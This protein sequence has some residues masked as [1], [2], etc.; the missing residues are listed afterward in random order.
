M[1][2]EANRDAYG[3]GRD[4]IVVNV[5]TGAEQ[6]QARSG[7]RIWGNVPARN[8]AFT[9]REELLRAVRGALLSGDQ[10]V[11]Q[12]L[13]GMGGVG[14]TQL[15]IEYAHRFASGYDVVWWVNAEQP[16]LIGEQF[17]MLAARLG[18]G[19]QGTPSP[20]LRQAVLNELRERQ[21]W[22]LVFD[23]PEKPE[24]IADWLPGGAGHV[25]IPSRAHG[26]G[27]RAG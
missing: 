15:A 12:A 10:A 27:G 17:A 5:T 26:W 11:V 21:S 8:P 3:A 25:L 7:R 20:L 16:S 14:K 1:A 18:A 4:Q 9:G 13:H 19:E 23:N 22:L 24:D 2:Y 6:P